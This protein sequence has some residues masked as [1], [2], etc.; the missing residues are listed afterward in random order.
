MRICGCSIAA[1]NI[2]T[3]LGCFINDSPQKHGK[4]YCKAVAIDGISHIFIFSS[5]LIRAATEPQQNYG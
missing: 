1:S 5:T 2:T 4:C 3:R